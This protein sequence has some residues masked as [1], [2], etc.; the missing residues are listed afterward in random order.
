VSPGTAGRASCP[1]SSCR[2]GGQTIRIACSNRRR[3]FGSA[4][5]PAAKSVTRWRETAPAA[6]FV[7]WRGWFCR[8]VPRRARTMC[9][10]EGRRRYSGRLRCLSPTLTRRCGGYAHGGRRAP[11]GLRRCRN[12][13]R[14]ESVGR[15]AS[16]IRSR[17]SL[18][19]LSGA[20]GG[21]PV[22]ALVLGICTRGAGT[23]RRAPGQLVG[24][25]QIVPLSSLGRSGVRSRSRSRWEDRRTGRLRGRSARGETR[26]DERL[27]VG[28]GQC[29]K[30]RT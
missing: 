21:V 24:G 12:T 19:P 8:R 4:S 14:N 26:K 3:Q 11:R 17:I 6:G 2:F 18:P 5:R 1:G 25:P 16:W 22:R 9:L 29:W 7:K 27:D 23:A 30:I 13:G 20:S 10:S 15:P 28:I